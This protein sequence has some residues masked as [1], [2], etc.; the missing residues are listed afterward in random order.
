MGLWWRFAE[1]GFYL[2]DLVWVGRGEGF[3]L[4]CFVRAVAME[5]V[6]MVSSYDDSHSS[7]L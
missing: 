1:W 7:A 6:C 5:N 2:V 3:L 4:G